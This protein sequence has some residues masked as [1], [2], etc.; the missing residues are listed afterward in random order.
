MRW[1]E[2][3][4]SPVRQSGQWQ[5]TMSTVETA[6]KSMKVLLAW[7]PRCT[8]ARRTFGKALPVMRSNKESSHRWQADVTHVICDGRRRSGPMMAKLGAKQLERL[9]D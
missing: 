4:C 8:R 6:S 2:K 5:P 1:P 3:G 9:E 7:I